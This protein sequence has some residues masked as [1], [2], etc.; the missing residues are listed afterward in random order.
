MLFHTLLLELTSSKDHVSAPSTRTEAALALREEALL[1]VL[2]QTV[3]QDTGQDL[4]CYGQEEYSSVVITGLAISLPLIDV[5]GCGIPE[6][7]RQVRCFWYHID[8]NMLVS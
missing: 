5:H 7:L 2:Q 4:A 3:E 6:F 1:Q 8:W